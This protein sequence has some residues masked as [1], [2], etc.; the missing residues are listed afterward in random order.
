LFFD[1]TITEVR[2][3]TQQEIEHGHVHAAGA[4]QDSCNDDSCESCD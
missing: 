3:A 2:D 4:K 1:V